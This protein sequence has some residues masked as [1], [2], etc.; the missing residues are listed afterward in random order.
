MTVRSA[1][2]QSTRS[3]TPS[4][5]NSSGSGGS[6]T[7]SSTTEDTFETE[8]SPP[9]ARIAGEKPPRSPRLPYLDALS[10]SS[11]QPSPSPAR[12]TFGCVAVNNDLGNEREDVIQ[13]PSI[14][15]NGIGERGVEEGYNPPSAISSSSSPSPLTPAQRYPGW[16]YQHVRPLEEFIDDVDPRD[17]YTD[18]QEIAEGESGSVFSARVVKAS[19]N[20]FV[21]IKQIPIMP[22]GTPKLTDLRR[23]LTLMKDV[24]HE[25]VLPMDTL[26]VDLL[27][28][29]L[30]IRMELMDRSLADVIALIGDGVSIPETAMARFASDVLHGLQYLQS[31]NVAHRDIRS[32]NMLLDGEGVLKI[33]DFSTAVR[34]SPDAPACSD[35]VGVIYWQ[36]PEIRKG[37][38]DALKVDVWSLGATTWEMAQSEPPF[39]D[40]QNPRDFPEQW[41]ALD[42]S[43][44]YSES[45][46]DFLDLCSRPHSIRPTPAEL[47]EASFIRKAC[48]RSVIN[49]L[50]SDCRDIEERLHRRQSVGSQGTIS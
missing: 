47:L 27:E 49:Q 11:P 30:W 7:A 32:D 12:S 40:I 50:L 17:L 18:L 24:R 35:V 23:E 39:S 8:V 13:R 4:N 41:P 43:D 10:A 1:S 6:G 16:L 3:S 26:Y 29:S 22:S 45:F 42:Q 34:V 21:A 14:V 44:L 33:A 25:N 9:V 2:P 28:D 38:Y 31:H 15:I 19:S 36:A 37:S 5:S 20:S 46:H 48:S